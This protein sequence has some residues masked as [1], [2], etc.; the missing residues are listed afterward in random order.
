VIDA[1]LLLLRVTVGSLLAGHGAQKLFG[2]FE[3]PGIEGASGMVHSMGFRPAR[4]WAMAAGW[5]EF[6]GGLLTAVGWFSPLGQLSAACSMLVATFKVHRGKPVWV[7]SGGAELPITNMAALG[8]ITL[9]GPGRWSLDRLFGVK[10]PAWFNIMAFLA[11]G[12]GT[13]LSIL[14]ADEV[15][16]RSQTPNQSQPPEEPI[17]QDVQP[18]ATLPAG[19]ME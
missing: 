18:E 19:S 7:T 10:V 12:A 11:A 9:A 1:A 14:R 15:Q 8:A 4:P 17:R 6:G 13:Y 2:S 5:A 3:G 16:R